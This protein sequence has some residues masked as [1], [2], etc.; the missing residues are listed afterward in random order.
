MDHPVLRFSQAI[1]YL[2]QLALPRL[3]GFLLQFQHHIG[4]V[5]PYK[6][7]ED[8]FQRSHI[9]SFVPHRVPRSG[10]PRILEQVI[11]ATTLSAKKTKSQVGH[12]QIPCV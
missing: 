2:E 5:P 8:N 11:Q 7:E 10:R 6:V 1:I 12:M 4:A 3:P 9:S